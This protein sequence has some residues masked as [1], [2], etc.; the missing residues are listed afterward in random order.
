MNL[1]WFLVGV[2][3]GMMFCFLALF[4]LGAYRVAS[5]A[6]RRAGYIQDDDLEV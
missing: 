4:L 2:V 6:D 5:D 1:L 3:A